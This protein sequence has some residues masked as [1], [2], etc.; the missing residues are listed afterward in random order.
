MKFRIL[1]LLIVMIILNFTLKSQQVSTLLTDAQ[2]EFESIHWLEDGRILSADYTNGNLYEIKLDGTVSTL[3]TGFSNLA[4][5][6]IDKAGNFYFSG[7]AAG[8]VLKLNEDNSYSEVTSGI[9]Q[10]V[11]VL[12]TD[13]EDEIYVASYGASTLYL[14][15]T[16]TGTKTSFAVANGINGPDA[17]VY[18]DDGDILI[19]NFNNNRIHKVTSG[20]EVSLFATIPSN[21]FLG[22]LALGESKIYTAAFSG[23]KI[24]EVTMDG[25]ITHIAG[26]GE[27][28]KVDGSALDATFTTPNGVALSP[29]GDTLLVTDAASVR[30]IT[31]L[32]TVSDVIEEEFE[33]SFVLSPNPVIDLLTVNLKQEIELKKWEIIDQQGKLVKVQNLDTIPTTPFTVSTSDLADGVYT[34]RLTSEKQ[35]IQVKSFVKAGN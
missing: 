6:G 18:H 1:L 21:G 19:A 3:V 24:Y 4:G 12:P 25:Q 20:G 23:K 14:V 17:I 8:T 11:G 13:N 2:R 22:Y 30:M 28:G 34:F 35:K 26:S 33:A 10:P 5:G 7:I 31:G 15:N 9:N 32:N 29:T 27:E 16:A